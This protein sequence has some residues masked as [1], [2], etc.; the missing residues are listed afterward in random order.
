MSDQNLQTI[1]RLY[2]AMAARDAAVIADCF[3]DDVSIY[4]TPELPWGG[5]RHGHDGVLNF[6]LTILEHI[7]SRV[8]H[9]VIYA[10][11]DHVVQRGRTKGTTTRG[12]VTF[13]VAETHLFELRDGKIIRFEVYI[14]T[15]AMLD[16]LERAQA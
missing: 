1:H 2:E 10:A 5:D 9:D 16:A 11:G 6:F 15:P 14:D 3:A 8:E 4:Q 13:D 7:Q 12:V